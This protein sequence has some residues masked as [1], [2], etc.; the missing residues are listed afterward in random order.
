MTEDMKVWGKPP[1]HTHR[2]PPDS[3]G[4]LMESAGFTI[5]ESKLLGNKTKAL[6]LIGKKNN[7]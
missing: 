5:E 2:F 3:L 7:T 1:E 6:Y 4:S